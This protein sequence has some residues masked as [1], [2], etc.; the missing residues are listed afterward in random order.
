VTGRVDGNIRGLARRDVLRHALIGG[1][2]LVGLGALGACGDGGSDSSGSGTITMKLGSDSP[3]DAPHTAAMVTM[4]K[5]IEANTGGRVRCKLF[6]NGTLGANDVMLNSIK[7]GTLDAMICDLAVPS[8]AVPACNLFSLPFLFEDAEHA[9]RVAQGPIGADLTPKLESAFGCEVIGW[10]SDGD[11]NL[12]N[13][14]HPITTPADLAGLKIRTQQSPIQEDTYRAFKA[15][16]SPLSA[17]EVYSAL[18]TGVI[19][20]AGEPAPDAL[21]QRFYEV[22]K[23]YTVGSIFTYTQ[24]IPV[25]AKF[26]Q[27]LSKADQDVVRSA[28]QAGGA[29]NARATFGAQA[30]DIDALKGK[31]L[32]V[33]DMTDRQAF[34]DIAKTVWTKDADQVGGMALIERAAS[35]T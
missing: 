14:K 18:Q 2:G 34:V 12:L 24:W 20:G 27:K 22:A 6:P 17:T 23:Y 31:G 35:S 29:A 26:L 32:H 13:K 4:M 16:P 28:G 8:T 19:D 1:A 9:L 30:A 3:V 7:A 10:G 11:V 15:L 5:E 25:S 21:T 33:V